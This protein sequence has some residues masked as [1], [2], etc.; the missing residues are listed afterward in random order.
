MLMK[1][2]TQRHAIIIAEL[3]GAQIIEVS[4][5]IDVGEN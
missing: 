3:I 1:L 4:L 5:L 2:V